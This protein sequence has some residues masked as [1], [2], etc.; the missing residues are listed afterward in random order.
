MHYLCPR[1]HFY[2]DNFGTE[3]GFEHHTHILNYFYPR[4]NNLFWW[5]LRTVECLLLIIDVEISTIHFR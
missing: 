1:F 4:D 5:E 2:V 3:F